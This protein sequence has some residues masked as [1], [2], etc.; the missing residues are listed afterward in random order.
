MIRVWTR[1][2]KMTFADADSYSITPVP[3]SNP[4]TPTNWVLE[5]DW[6]EPLPGSLK[7]YRDSSDSDYDGHEMLA[8]FAPGGWIGLDFTESE[9]QAQQ[10]PEPMGFRGPRRE[11]EYGSDEPHGP[12]T[13]SRA[14]PKTTSLPIPKTTPVE[15]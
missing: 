3:P 7:I 10:I 5:H 15:R 9:P 13:T 4:M 14:L 1:A 6:M 12:R 2:G 11:P 8:W